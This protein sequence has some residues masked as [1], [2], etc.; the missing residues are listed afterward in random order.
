M[1]RREFIKITVGLVS[2]LPPAAWA[3]RIWRVG[4]LETQSAE[5]N[6]TNFAAFRQ[7]LSGL[8]YVQGRNLEIDY[9]SADG[10]AERFSQLAAMLVAAKID[11]IVTRGT[12]AARAAQTASSTIPVVMAASGEPLTT[13]IVAS[14]ARPGG[15]VTGLSAF[16]NEL[17]PK[18]IELLT[19]TI[20]GIKRVAFLQ[21]MANP[22]SQ[23]QWEELKSA[24]H[25]ARLEAVLLDIRNSNELAP[26]FESAVAQRVDALL[27][28]NDTV[29]QANRRQIVELAVQHRL[30]AIYA[31][32][33][34][35]EAG[36]LMVYAV[37]YADLYRRAAIYVDKIFRGAK[38]SELPVQQP[39]KFELIINLKAA[40]AL[41]VTV[42]PTLLARADEVIE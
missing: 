41:G 38:P 10:K 37:D 17:I 27:V 20:P 33:E 4:M 2:L 34:F 28:G 18:R 1:R 21:D 35:V 39:D 19:E 9:R 24:A 22:V 30:P 11:V 12:L 23:S 5:A 6:A 40:K 3:Q 14:L 31:T 15:N 26:A 42:S 8:G 36:G 7:S 32:R 16:T 25:S 29:T 13:G